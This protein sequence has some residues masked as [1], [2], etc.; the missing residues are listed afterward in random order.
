M[1]SYTDNVK[2]RAFLMLDAI[3]LN[4]ANAEVVSSCDFS[5]TENVFGEQTITF[6]ISFSG[7]SP[8]SNA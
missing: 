3:R 2:A 6:R 8:K 5:T 4:I 7:G 1:M